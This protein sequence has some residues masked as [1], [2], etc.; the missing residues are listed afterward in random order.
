MQQVT[1]TLQI[2]GLGR[3]EPRGPTASL[4]LCCP[5]LG[6]WSTGIR[7]AGPGQLGFPTETWGHRRLLVW[8]SAPGKS[9]ACLWLTDSTLPAWTA[10]AHCK[11]ANVRT[12]W[13]RLG[14]AG[15]WLRHWNGAGPG[16][17][18]FELLGLCD[19]GLGLGRRGLMGQ[20]FL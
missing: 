19:L 4:H 18:Q 6:M 14:H 16:D 9:P 20:H 15:D 13:F 7:W 12:Y 5:G 3:S 1:S 17:G 11:C 2:P 10:R 8:P